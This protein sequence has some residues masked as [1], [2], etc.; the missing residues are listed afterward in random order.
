[1]PLE[2]SKKCPHESPVTTALFCFAQVSCEGVFNPRL[3]PR[4]EVHQHYPGKQ[5]SF[6]NLFSVTVA[7]RPRVIGDTGEI[8]LEDVVQVAKW[9]KLNK[10]ML[11]LHW[12]GSCDS[13]EFWEKRKTISVE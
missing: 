3:D 8:T 4:V 1:M 2:S 7:D 13:I 6:E 12:F 9:V 5:A 10:E 11:L